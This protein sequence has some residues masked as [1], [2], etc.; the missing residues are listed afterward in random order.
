MC[1][2]EMGN[3]KIGN[4]FNWTP[5]NVI[6]SDFIKPYLYGALEADLPQQIVEYRNLWDQRIR[7]I[8]DESKE[9]I[10]DAVKD[11]SPILLLDKTDKSKHI[12][13]KLW[14]K[15]INKNVLYIILDPVLD[16]YKRPYFWENFRH[17][18]YSS[19]KPINQYYS[20]ENC[21][22]DPALSNFVNNK[23]YNWLYLPKTGKIQ[24]LLQ[25]LWNKA[26]LNDV[27]DQ[28]AML[29]Y[30]TWIDGE[31]FVDF[32]DEKPS[33]ILS[34]NYIDRNIYPLKEWKY[35]IANLLMISSSPI[36]EN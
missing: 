23:N 34:S 15:N 11:M 25:N 6:Y 1:T 10:K 13:F 29:M 9:K 16:F 31:F 19:I 12:F 24:E 32:E 27:S 5:K 30:L 33:S 18:K 17:I 21:I 35:L 2:I 14:D 20:T 4:N 22:K 8:S 36:S 7:G 26:E 3:E 28:I